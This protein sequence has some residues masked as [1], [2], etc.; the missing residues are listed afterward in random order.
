MSRKPAPAFS[1]I[2][3]IK[4]ARARFLLALLPIM[5]TFLLLWQV[6]LGN[7]PPGAGLSD[8][9]V[10]GWT[11][12]VWVIYLRLVTVRLRTTVSHNVLKI[13]LSGLWTLRK[14]PLTSVTRAEGVTYDARREYRGYGVRSNGKDRSYI[15]SGDTGV[16]LTLKDGSSLL[17]GTQNPVRLIKALS[18]R[19]FVDEG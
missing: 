10:I 6:G 17:V 19:R 16:R 1:E 14:I 8:N 7:A 2:Q 13:A 9:E 4:Q 5:L 12:F 18:D 11:I 15:A 3:S